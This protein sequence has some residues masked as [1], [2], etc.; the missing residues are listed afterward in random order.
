L[1]GTACV[2]TGRNRGLTASGWAGFLAAHA[3][4]G[5]TAAV[6]SPR[7]NPIHALLIITFHTTLE[8]NMRRIAWIPVV[9]LLSSCSIK[10]Y[11]V[12]QLGDA[13]AGLD[14]SIAADD[15]PELVRGALPFSLKLIETL[16]I[17]S[18]QDPKLLLS[19]ATGFTQYAYAFVQEDADEA[20]DTDRARA[21]ALRAR[22]AKLYI[23]ARDYGLRGLAVKH[24][25]F[26]TGLKADPKKAVG[27]LGK[28]EV[29]LMYWTT[30]AWA[31][32]LS[33]SHDLAMLPEIPRFEA[34]SDRVVALD[35]E[36]NEGAIHGFLITYEMSRLKP[37]PD[38]VAIARAHFERNLA[39]A[40]GHQAAP[41][42]TFAESVLVAQKDR[43]GFESTLREALKIN[44]NTWPEHRELNLLM[45]R[46]ARWLLSRTDKLFPPPKT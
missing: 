15:D 6:C 35:D 37:K 42:V 30:L 27:Q 10:R 24:R 38:R 20:E 29:P 40:H 2:K 4:R 45:Q 41:Y 7:Y 13:L 5:L 25:D 18:P 22:A 28:S 39:L 12:R 11:A 3:M 31:A 16:I 17:D 1:T 44:P 43:A 26:I 34:L 9:F 19:A 23:R 14:V 32:A 21:T 33:A 8:S 36:Y 46:R